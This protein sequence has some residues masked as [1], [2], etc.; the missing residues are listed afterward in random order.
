VETQID[1]FDEDQIKSLFDF[2]DAQGESSGGA[3]RKVLEAKVHSQQERLKLR[4]NI[5]NAVKMPDE[6]ASMLDLFLDI[7]PDVIAQQL[8][9]IDFTIYCDLRSTELLNQSWNKQKLK[10]RSPT[11][12]N[13][14]QRSTRLSMWVA[15][16]VLYADKIMQRA[17]VLEKMIDIA[18][19]LRSFGNFNTLMGMIAGLN[20]SA[21][22]RL[23]ATSKKI[24]KEKRKALEDL[25]ELMSPEGSYKNYRAVIS[26][27][28]PPTIPYIGVSLTDLTFIEEG[29][30]DMLNGQINFRKRQMT[31]KVIREVIQYQNMPYQFAPTEPLHIFLQELA[32]NPSDTELYD[33]S[34]HVEPKQDKKK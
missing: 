6:G 18:Q 19:L 15:S 8:T 34:L 17:K 14:I 26:S 21:V 25:V 16:V 24:P 12:V 5:P 1:D 3:F 11:V 32:Y 33:L 2:A 23:K 13:L 9:L 27:C 29:N 20:L 31:Y 10:Y 28:S 22:H 7:T 4:F 30:P